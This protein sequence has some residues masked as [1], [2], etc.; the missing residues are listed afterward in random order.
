MKG[1]ME[2]GILERT[3]SSRESMSLL[4]STWAHVTQ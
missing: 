4:L 2:I 3:G 1:R